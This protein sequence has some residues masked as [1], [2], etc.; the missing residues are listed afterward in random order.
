M[1]DDPFQGDVRKLEG[2][3]VRWRKRVGNYRVFFRPEIA[4]RTVLISSVARR[5]STTY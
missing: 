4:A 1:A 5:T 3:P 2:E